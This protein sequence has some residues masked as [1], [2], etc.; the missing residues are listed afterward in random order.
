MPND[1]Q[2]IAKGQGLL[3]MYPSFGEE[4]PNLELDALKMRATNLAQRVQNR[5][6]N[7][8]MNQNKLDFIP[9]ALRRS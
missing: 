6:P 7:P 8:A 2:N 4:S 3:K 1:F 5:S 9:P